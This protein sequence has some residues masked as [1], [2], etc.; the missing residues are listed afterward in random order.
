LAQ[1]AVDGVSDGRQAFRSEGAD[2]YTFS[3]GLGAQTLG[4]TANGSGN[5]GGFGIYARG[6]NGNV[7]GTL[8]GIGVKAVGGDGRGAGSYGGAGIDAWGGNNPDGTLARA[9]EFHGDVN[10]SGCVA[11]ST[12][13]IGGSCQSDIRL[14]KNIQPFPAV[15]D[16]VVQ[17][18][19]VSYTWR[20]DEYPQFHFGTSRTSGLIAQEVEKVFPEMVS[21]DEG[22]FKRVNYSELP[23]LMLQGI[24]ELK[25]ENDDLRAR[26]RRLEAALSTQ[27]A[28]QN[29]KSTAA[30][31]KLPR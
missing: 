9:G 18:Q 4:G 8:G 16:K 14:K 6:G 12:V 26:I 5:A 20:T 11:A 31:P 21:V 24:R 30:L 19:P 10:I 2:G 25:A 13:I 17:L 23:Y 3:G 1:L 29:A 22:G 27:E 28:F 7:S 15:L